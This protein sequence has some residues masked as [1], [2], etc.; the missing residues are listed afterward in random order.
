M[1][2]SSPLVPALSAALLAAACSGGAQPSGSP[3][4]APAAT[5]LPAPAP[6][7]SDPIGSVPT[8]PPPIGSVPT[9]AP[10][11]GLWL[12]ATQGLYLLDQPLPGEPAFAGSVEV[13]LGA[14]PPPPDT[15]VTLNGVP[16]QPRALAGL[17][18]VFWTLDAAA[19]QPAPAADGSLRLEARSG[20]AS[21][22]LTLPCPADVALS[23][24]PPLGSALAAGGTL[25]LGWAAPLPANAV[26]VLPSDFFA[27]ALLRGLDLASLAPAIDALALRVVPRPATG[28]TLDVGATDQSGYLAELT[29]Q[30][31]VVVDGSSAG[32]CGRK[33]R[34]LYTR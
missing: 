15:T 2:R 24:A 19:A 25:A 33:K 5:A 6:P 1:R 7:P 12:R 16:L 34:L 28:V 32:F 14:D 9:P 30:G 18:R 22:T 21:R 29:W 13:R 4:P 23:S 26:N 11:S 17:P 20:G 3:P 27:S 10:P 31:P 8:P